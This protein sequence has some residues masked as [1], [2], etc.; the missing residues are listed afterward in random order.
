[1]FSTKKDAVKTVDGKNV[2]EF[3]QVVS[4]EDTVAPAL[5]GTK[6]VNASTV[7]LQFSEPLKTK[8]T[9]I[10]KLADGTDI[11]SL[12]V[13][14]VVGSNIQLNLS[15]ASIPVKENIQ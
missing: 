9:V 5:L 15:N 12:V 1:M 3:N 13:S 6:T 11:S 2:A 10:A 4:Y 14:N 7:N 8:G